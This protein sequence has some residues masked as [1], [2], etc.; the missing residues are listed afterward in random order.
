MNELAANIEQIRNRIATACRRAGRDV[1][2]VLLLGVTK[3]VPPEMVD[4]AVAA[5]L[6]VF[7]ES[8]VQEAQAK[9]PVVAGRT[10]WHF[11]GHLQTN[12][13]RAA[14]ALFDL[15]Q[16]VDSLK[17][18]AELDKWAAH[19]GKIQPVLLEINLAGEASKHGLRVEDAPAALAEINR[20]TH[21]EVRGLMAIPPAAPT[22]DQTRPYFRQLRQLR[23]Q[24]GVPELSMGMSHDFEIAVEEG[25]TIVR[26]GAAIFGERKRY[27][28]AE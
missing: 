18:A 17:L 26:V 11:I 1:G 12:K 21:L 10:H 16:S 9:I 19:A 20:F 23:D 24:L 22:P 6:T 25:A 4:A 2:A 13:A 5:G 14:V 8:K 7:G 15:I 28:P 27:E 3:T